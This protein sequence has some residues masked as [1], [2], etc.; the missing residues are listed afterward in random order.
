MIGSKL[1]MKCCKSLS[2]VILGTFGEGCMW[3]NVRE[4]ESAKVTFKESVYWQLKPGSL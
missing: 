2:F 4:K 3:E 1:A